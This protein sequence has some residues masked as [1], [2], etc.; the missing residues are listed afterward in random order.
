MKQF[1]TKLLDEFVPNIIKTAISTICSSYSLP[2][3]EPDRGAQYSSQTLS[4]MH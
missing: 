3:W 4:F 2:I 1:K